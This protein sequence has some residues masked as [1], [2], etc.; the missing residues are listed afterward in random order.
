VKK[1]F[2]RWLQTMAP[3]GVE[4]H[5]DHFLALDDPDANLIAVI[6]ASGTLGSA[7]SKRLL[8]P[9]Y[10][11]ETGGHHPFVDAAQRLEPVD[12]RYGE[13]I[14][15]EVTY[16]LPAGL[17]IEGAP[18]NAKIPWEGHAVAVFKTESGNG[19]VTMTRQFARAFTMA[20]PEE[21]QNLRDFYQKVASADQQQLVLN[22]SIAGKGN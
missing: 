8:L 9:G 1:Q 15:D 10:F 7:T 5:V 21:Y 6:K 4:A 11:F 2:D 13:E 14:T 16:H 22:T 20:K 18:Q 3:Q 19:S 12:M 17:S